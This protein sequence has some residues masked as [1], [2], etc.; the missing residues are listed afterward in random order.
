MLDGST[1]KGFIDNDAILLIYCDID[2]HDEKFHTKTVYFKLIRPKSVTAEGLFDVVQKCLNGLGIQS[3][4]IENCQKLVGIGASANIANARLKG[5][6]GKKLG[7]LDVVFSPPLRA[8]HKRCSEW[9]L[10]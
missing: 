1:D 8:G 2:D 5:I 10:F 3:V 6:I 4:D 7:L 9:Y